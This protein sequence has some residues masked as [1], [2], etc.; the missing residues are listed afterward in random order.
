MA[1]GRLFVQEKFD[2]QAKKNVSKI[3]ILESKMPLANLNRLGIDIH[4]Y[5]LEIL[6]K[7]W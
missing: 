3:Y 7:E 2:E 4:D 5:V 1:V 6:I